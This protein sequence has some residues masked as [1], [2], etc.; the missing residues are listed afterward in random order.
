MARLHSALTDM[1]VSGVV[2]TANTRSSPAGDLVWSANTILDSIRKNINIKI[3][4]VRK[5]I[6]IQNLLDKDLC[7]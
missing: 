1:E 4:I 7:K 2:N 6:F 3:I 5:K